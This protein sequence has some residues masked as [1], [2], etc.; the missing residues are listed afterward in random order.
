MTSCGTG[1]TSPF[2]VCTDYYG[3]DTPGYKAM[4]QATDGRRSSYYCQSDI[5]QFIES[6][7]PAVD[8]LKTIYNTAKTDPNPILEFAKGFDKT[9]SNGP[10]MTNRFFTDDSKPYEPNTIT[11]D[12]EFKTKMPLLFYETLMMF[13]LMET[14][15][16]P[17]SITS[18]TYTCGDNTRPVY[19]KYGSYFNDK[20]KDAFICMTDDNV[21]KPIFFVD[22][23]DTSKRTK[24][25]V[26]YILYEILDKEGKVCSGDTCDITEEDKFDFDNTPSRYIGHVLVKS[27]G[28]IQPSDVSFITSS[29][30]L[31]IIG[32]SLLLCGIYYLYMRGHHGDMITHMNNIEPGAGNQA[33]ARANAAKSA[34]RH[35]M[36]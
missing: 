24:T 22:P 26:P 5:I 27:D 9:F 19:L 35:A 1:S 7:D 3:N 30:L 2:C 36:T 13:S 17:T 10:S 20:G 8:D 11:T 4:Y 23:D 25:Q 6:G 29:L 34:N 21:K 14:I 33:A 12:P 16:L 18:T 32:L 15:D 28:N 31:V